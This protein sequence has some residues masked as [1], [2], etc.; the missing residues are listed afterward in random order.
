MNQ[1]GGYVPEFSE[2][3]S[4]AQQRPDTETPVK[5][6]FSYHVI[7][8]DIRATSCPLLPMKPEI[9]KQLTQQR[10]S[11]PF[12]RATPESQSQMVDLAHPTKRPAGRFS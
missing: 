8:V 11:R 3:L 5:T 2:A 10:N 9:S 12:G 7:R 1:P 4:K 6:Q